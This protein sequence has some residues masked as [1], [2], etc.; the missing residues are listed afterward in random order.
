MSFDYLR[1]QCSA[2]V[3]SIAGVEPDDGQDVDV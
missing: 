2:D 3:F 1:N